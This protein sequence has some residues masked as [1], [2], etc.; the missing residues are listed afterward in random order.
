MACAFSFSACT[1]EIL[2]RRGMIV[3]N[4]YLIIMSDSRNRN[5]V[6]DGGGGGEDDNDKSFKIKI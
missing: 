3:Y 4:E 5:T 2:K 1:L 6:Y